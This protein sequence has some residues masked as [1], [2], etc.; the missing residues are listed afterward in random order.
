[1]LDMQLKKHPLSETHEGAYVLFVNSDSGID[2]EQRVFL[3][4]LTIDFDALAAQT[5][6]TATLEATLVCQGRR[7][8][9][10]VWVLIVGLG[11]VS[12]NASEVLTSLRLA[13]ARSIRY[14]ENTVIAN[15]ACEFPTFNVP[16]LDTFAVAQELAT[17]WMTAA[18]QFNTYM[19]DQER[20]LRGSYQITLIA[21]EAE[22]E[23]IQTG[24]DRGVWEGFAVNQAR[25]WCDMPPCDLTPTTLADH[26]AEIASAH[27]NLSCQVFAKKE[28]EALGMGGILAVS[29]GSSQEPRLIVAEYKPE[30]SYTQTV[31]LVGKGVTFDSGGISIK[32]SQNM[33][34]MKDDMAGA[35]TV[36]AAMQAIAHLKPHVRV[37]AVAPLTE[38]M[39][40]GSATKPGDIIYHYN[41]KT[42]EIKNTDAE[43]R[44]I[45]ADALAYICKQYELD[46]LVD[47]ATL[48]G[49][50]AY[51]LGPFYAGLMTRTFGLREQLVAAGE[52]SGDRVWPLPFTDEYKKAVVSDVADV[53]NIGKDG[54]RAGAITAGMFLEHFVDETVAWA[55]L[56]IAGVSFKVLNKCHLRSTGATGF[57]VRLLVAML[58]NMH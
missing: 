37:I 26:F 12:T 21:R 58:M 10:L 20:H 32:P 36:L 41:G 43:G 14:F 42:S 56:D 51:A 35:A 40:G 15:F 9:T 1:M 47:L 45:L 52:I 38:N 49:A 11:T 54:Y 44:L 22:H 6:F 19:T 16:G 46:I 27:D 24:W 48:T 34:E 25:L 4:G 13:A 23:A 5:K 50:C 17:A 18:Y 53:C 28:L 7:G 55:H 39:P 33:D 57:G 2:K 30:G 31:G 29:Q 3:E 8:D